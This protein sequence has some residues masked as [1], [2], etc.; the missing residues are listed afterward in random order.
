MAIRVFVSFRYSDGN[1][2]K[3]ELD[4][5]FEGTVEVINCSE[6]EDRSNMSESTIKRYLYRKLKSTSVTIFIVTP[7]SV[8][9]KKDWFGD[10]DDWIYDEL[11]YSLEDREENR[12]NGMIA[13]Y[14]PETKN[15]LMKDCIH[16]CSYCHKNQ[17]TNELYDFDNIIR[18]NML[19]VKY[20]YKHNLCENLYDGDKD[21]YCSLV[22][23]DEFINDVEGYIDKAIAK[24]DRNHEF[25]LTK[26]L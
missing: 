2:Y 10:Y 5:I 19:N 20:Q 16:I 18:K 24:R 23:W 26:R 7:E 15:L 21:S 13:V 12:T 14:T 1:K 9:H 17:K 11:R 6:N 3:E 22:S 4:K 25:V 8:N